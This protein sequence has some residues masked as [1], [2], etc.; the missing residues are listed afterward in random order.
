MVPTT[1]SHSVCL[2]CGYTLGPELEDRPCSEC[3]SQMR[4]TDMRRDVERILHNPLHLIVYALRLRPLPMGWWWSFC[5]RKDTR[6]SRHRLLAALVTGVGLCVVAGYLGNSARIE[7]VREHVAVWKGSDGTSLLVSP[8]GT[9]VTIFS[10]SKGW[11]TK[12][13]WEGEGPDFSGDQAYVRAV[14]SGKL[15]GA[16]AESHVQRVSRRLFFEFDGLSLTRI[17]VACALLL[18][19]WAAPFALL[20]LNLL[21]L[22]NLTPEARASVR[23]ASRNSALWI[24]LAGLSA[25]AAASVDVCVRYQFAT[26]SSPGPSPLRLFLLSLPLITL[27][28]GWTLTIKSDRTGRLWRRRH[29]INSIN[30]NSRK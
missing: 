28:A 16:R 14:V 26:A 7:V 10:A 5:K 19:T 25:L 6:Q 29:C 30:R 2:N 17:P 8:M 13:T 11:T 22:R 3:G 1:H 21:R 4:P 9:D 20:R 18:G 12:P 24:P 15:R 23:N 27:V